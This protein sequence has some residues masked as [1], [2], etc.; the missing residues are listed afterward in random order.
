MAHNL[1]IAKGDPQ[2]PKW[3]W[4]LAGGR[5]KL[6]ESRGKMTPAR[7]ENDE[8]THSRIRVWR[9]LLWRTRPASLQNEVAAFEREIALA[10]AS[11]VA[12]RQAVEQVYRQ[13]R[14]RTIEQLVQR[15]PAP[16]G[17][18]VRNL[19]ETCLPREP[20]TSGPDFHCD[21]GLGGLAKLL[22]AA[23]YDAAFWPGIDDDRLLDKSLA[24]AA[25]LLTNDTLLVG[26]GVI[27]DGVVPALLVPITM[28]KSEQFAHVVGRLE[29]PLA[30]PRCMS[31]GG[32]LQP[33]D[34]Q[35][36]RDR[37]PP[38]TWP[39]RDDYYVCERCQKLFWEGTHWQKIRQHLAAATRQADP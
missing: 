32:R 2:R 34:K 14:D 18:K 5:G 24:S 25:I 38:R 1:F 8:R 37:I 26:R 29:L 3:E 9:N 21:A 13:L 12:E 33:V 10:V 23:G 31:C 19:L 39:W 4:R 16:S 27:R 30:A 17:R 11:G 15:S 35:T 22:R 7:S 28:R 6:A 36:V 20:I